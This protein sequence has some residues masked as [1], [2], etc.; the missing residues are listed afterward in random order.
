MDLKLVRTD[1]IVRYRAV[2]EYHNHSNSSPAFQ[3]RVRLMTHH[4]I[5]A[6]LRVLDSLITFQRMVALELLPKA[7]QAKLKP[8]DR[9]STISILKVKFP[10][11]ESLKLVEARVEPSWAQTATRPKLS[12]G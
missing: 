6:P 5:R 7:N 10:R 3:D 4:S 11:M 2:W 12:Q 8:M 1:K 9:I